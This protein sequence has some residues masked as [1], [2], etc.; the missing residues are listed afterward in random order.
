LAGAETLAQ[1]EIISVDITKGSVKVS[2]CCRLCSCECVLC[3]LYFTAP[4]PLFFPVGYFL[5]YLRFGA[6]LYVCVP[7]YLDCLLTR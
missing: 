4:P 5:L 3:G 1:L 7:P 6:S 2:L